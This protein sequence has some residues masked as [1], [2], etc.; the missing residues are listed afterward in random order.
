MASIAWQ[1]ALVMDH[2]LRD[3]VE[4]VAK[5]I[6]GLDVSLFFQANPRTFDTPSGV[7]L[8]THRG[9]E[10]VT[11]VLERLAAHGY[12]ETFSRGDGRYIC[13]ALPKNPRVWTLLCRLSEAYLDHRE[14]RKEII[15]LL[16]NQQRNELE[17]RQ[18]EPEVTPPGS[19][20]H[21]A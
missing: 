14:S 12:L 5:T 1:G 13:Y 9:V 19:E 10:E 20:D 21:N 18:Q 4:N 17:E 6:V 16:I 15:R 2:P 3:F 11:E 7:A 8:R